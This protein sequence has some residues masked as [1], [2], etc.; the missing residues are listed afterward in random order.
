MK[1]SYNQLAK[2]LLDAY[3]RRSQ[4][5]MAQITEATVPSG[6]LIINQ[7]ELLESV[8]IVLH[9]SMK[10]HLNTTKGTE[11]L[12]AIIGPGELIGEVEALT[13]DLATCSVTAMTESRVA[14]IS[15]YAYRCWLKDDHEFTQLINRIISKRLQVL[16]K[17]SAIRLSYPMEYSVLK[18]LKMASIQNEPKKFDISKD[19]IANYLGTSVRSIN[20]IL[21]DLQNK[22]VLSTSKTIEI[23]SMDNLEKAL[24]AHNE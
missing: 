5:T 2:E 3:A 20:R 8:F 21:K 11:Y 6:T 17:R 24:R 7:E 23:I 4:Q 13:E 22:K 15:Q 9:G 12:V 18:L 19:G 16:T 10:I 1:S 14:K